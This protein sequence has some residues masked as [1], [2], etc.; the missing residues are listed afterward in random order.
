VRR[1]WQLIFALAVICLAILLYS[2]WTVPTNNTA[3]GHFDT[4]IVLGYPTNPDGS[5]SMEERARVAGA[6]AAYRAGDAAHIIMTG[7]PAH[8]HFVEAEVMAEVAEE[9]GVPESA[10][11]VEGK[12]RN[13][14]E[15]IWYSRRIMQQHG[16]ASAEVVSDPAHV[17]RASLILEHYGFAWKTRKANWPPEYGPL[18][19][20]TRYFYEMLA[21]SRVRWGGSPPTPYLPVK[22]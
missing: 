12:A 19:I 14:I 16:W 8:N 22:P 1:F 9:D 11:E 13:T 21:V 2:Y 17:V 18:Q 7:G 3:Q 15:N 20:G 4:L 10:I 6:V 5:P